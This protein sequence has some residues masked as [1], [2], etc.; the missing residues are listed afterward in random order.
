MDRGERIDDDIP[1]EPAHAPSRL[2]AGLMER[3]R[4]QAMERYRT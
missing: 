3:A 2:L 1:I 4:N